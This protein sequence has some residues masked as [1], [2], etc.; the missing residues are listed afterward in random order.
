MGYCTQTQS[1]EPTY[2]ELKRCFPFAFCYCRLRFEPTY[3]ELKPLEKA[4]NLDVGLLF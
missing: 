2:E 1:F 3:E 4:I